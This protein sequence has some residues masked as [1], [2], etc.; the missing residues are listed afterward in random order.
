[1]GLRVLEVGDR[2][3]GEHRAAGDVVEV[4]DHPA[5]LGR[6]LV[7]G[8]VGEQLVGVEEA[9]RRDWAWARAASMPG[10]QQRGVD[11]HLVDL[12]PDVGHAG[13]AVGLGD[14]L[15]QAHELVGLVAPWR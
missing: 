11:G 15:G 1:M 14:E 3:R 10:P 4:A 5:E 8:G 12:L 6:A 9:L 7:L 2:R 13:Q